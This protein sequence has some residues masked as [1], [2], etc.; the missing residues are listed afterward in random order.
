MVRNTVKDLKLN[1][2]AIYHDLVGAH[3]LRAGGVTALKLHGYD[4]TTIIKIG[5]WTYLKILQYIHNQISHLSK[6][7][8]EKMS[9]SLPFLNVAAI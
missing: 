9:I 8:S 6:E 1:L 3:L 5:Q 2:Q 7:I 4:D